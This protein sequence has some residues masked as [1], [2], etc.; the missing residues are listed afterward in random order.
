MK[1]VAVVT[2]ASSIGISASAWASDGAIDTTFGASGIARVGLSDADDGPTRCRPVL[3]PDQKILVCG[4]RLDNGATGSDFYVARFNTDGTLDGAFGTGGVVTIDFDRGS[5]GDHAEGLAL[6]PDGRVVVVGTTHGA[7]LQ[8]DDFAIARLDANGS[9]DATFASVGKT[10]VA[11]DL[12]GG[13]G[14][15]DVHAVAI[16]PDGTIV[17]AGSAETSGGHVVAVARLLGSGVGDMA[18]NSSGKVTFGYAQTANAGDD[19]AQGIAI[20]SEGRIVIAGTSC[21]GAPPMNT[22]QFG[23]ARLLAS[24]ELDAAFNGVGYTTVAF[25]PGTGLSNAVAMNVAL[26]ADGGMLVSGY[27]NTAPYGAVTNMDVA[28]ARLAGDGTLDATFANGGRL[29][30]PFDL[31]SDGFDA[32]TDAIEQ[33][34]GRIVLVGT[35][36]GD[37]TQYAIAARVTRDGMLDPAFGTMGS[38]TYDLGLATPGTQAFTGVSLQGTDILAGGIA[39]IPPVG[40]P[41]PLDGFVVRLTSGTSQQSTDS[42]FDASFD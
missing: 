36:L 30:I 18:F 32:A 29:L 6:Q 9:L 23:V 27:A 4:T 5:G 8:S 13:V 15:D 42:I 12:A 34:D 33:G 35:A 21:A 11:F 1:V 37:S 14:N 22:A 25:D 40:M 28:A 17:V 26:L 31:Q 10:T 16:A 20:D 39:F 7:G 19:D 3:Q 41:Q 2:L 24:G 38:Q